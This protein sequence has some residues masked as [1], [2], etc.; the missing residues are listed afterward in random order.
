MAQSAATW[1]AAREPARTDGAVGNAWLSNFMT[2]ADNL[3]Y[4]VDYVCVHNYN[5]VDAAGLQSW[6]EAEYAKYQRPIWLTEF[7]RDADGTTTAAEQL[8]YITDVVAML[9]SLP[10]IERYAYYNF[11]GNNSGLFNGDNSTNARGDVYAGI[12]SNPA[13]AI[14]NRKTADGGVGD[15]EQ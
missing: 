7:S 15:R 4:R 1:V 5:E 2:Q 10:F 14:L 6:L 8:A 13:T 3:G 9:E 12:V 11:L